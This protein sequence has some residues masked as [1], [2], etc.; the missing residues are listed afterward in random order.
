MLVECIDLVRS[1]K[2]DSD[3]AKAIALLAQQ[4]NA[5]LATET[6]TRREERNVSGGR[7]ALIGQLVLGESK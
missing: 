4:V 6:L 5:S 1:G 3:D 2:L 7:V